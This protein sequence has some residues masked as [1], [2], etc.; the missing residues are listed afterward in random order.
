MIPIRMDFPLLMNG[1]V[2]HLM[3]RSTR[4]ILAGWVE[5]GYLGETCVAADVG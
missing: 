2:A 3:G 1:V 5:E 4:H